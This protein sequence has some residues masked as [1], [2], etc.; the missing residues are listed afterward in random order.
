VLVNPWPDRGT[1]NATLP[2]PPAGEA[3]VDLYGK[4]QPAELLQLQPVTATILILVL[5]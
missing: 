3:W 4:E 5:K 2:P 1:L